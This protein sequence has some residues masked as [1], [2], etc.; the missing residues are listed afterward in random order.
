[1][2][3]APPFPARP[4]L[5][6]SI[7]VA[8]PGKKGFAQVCASARATVA[9]KAAMVTMTVTNILSGIVRENNALESN[10]VFIIPS[11]GKDFQE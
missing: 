4:Q 10:A 6:L 5:L 7:A 3:S 1:L 2:V 11:T 8:G 9:V